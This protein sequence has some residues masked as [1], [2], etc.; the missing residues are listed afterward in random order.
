MPRMSTAARLALIAVAIQ[1]AIATG[2]ATTRFFF[3][4][5]GPGQMFDDVRIFHEYASKAFQGLV[6]YRDYVLEYPVAAV[7][8]FVLPRLVARDYGAYKIA[9][10]IEMLLCNALAVWL[11]AQWVERTEGPRHI[12]GRLAWYSAFFAALCPMVVTKFDL[13]PMALSFGSAVASFS[14]RAVLGGLMTG[15]AILLKLYPG[16]LVVPGLVIEANRRRGRALIALAL[17][18]A[19]GSALWFGIGGSR[20]VRSLQYHTERGL[21]IEC[22]YSGI[23][24]LGAKV[25]QSPIATTYTHFSTELVS[26]GSAQLA[27]LAFPIQA[28]A[29][30]IVLVRSWRTRARE[31]MRDASAAILAFIVFGKVLSPQYVIWLF[32]FLAVVRGLTG[33]LARPIFLATCLA[34]TLIYP[35]GIDRLIGFDRLAVLLLNGRNAMLLVLWVL[36]LFGPAANRE[37]AGPVP[38]Q[39][40]RPE[41]RRQ[42]PEFPSYKE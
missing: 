27:W 32:P 13:A 17:T 34:T 18:V 40:G 15:A 26:P 30:L 2:T 19:V 3:G 11:V 42:R 12:A 28:A 7:P 21:E 8:V 38:L 41:P 23:L 37:P 4:G 14:G 20:V 31:P 25:F 39:E 35:W 22:L 5:A 16:V 29:L 1:A 24:A 10:G 9:F 6:P 36:L 33:A